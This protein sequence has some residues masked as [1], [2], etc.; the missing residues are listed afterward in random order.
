MGEAAPAPGAQEEERQGTLVL[1][2]CSK[3]GGR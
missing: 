1:A 2:E 3:V